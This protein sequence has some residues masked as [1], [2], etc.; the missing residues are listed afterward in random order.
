MQSLEDVEVVAKAISQVLP[1]RCLVL[2]EGAMGAGKTTLIRALA[3]T[4]GAHDVSSPTFAIHQSYLG[5]FQVI[6][7]FDLYRIENQDDLETSGLW[8]LL[9]LEK[10]SWIFIE[11][12]ERLE[13]QSLPKKISTY[14]LRIDWQKNDLRHV[15]L[16]KKMY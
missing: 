7:H 16:I 6:E 12:A 10:D 11:W 9:A 8:D 4:V 5:D 1:R 13:P 15:Q 2:F 3:R 14:C